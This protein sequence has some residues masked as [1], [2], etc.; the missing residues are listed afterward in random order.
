MST[1]STHVLDSATGRPAVGMEIELEAVR[2]GVWR[3]LGRGVTDD[4]GRLNTWL[5]TELT[6]QSNTQPNTGAEV[7]LGPGR[8]RLVFD[9]GGWSADLD[10]ECF[11]PEVGITFTVD[12]DGSHFHVPLL[13]AAYAYSTYRGS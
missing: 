10:R 8:Y 4:D 6:T 5:N 7:T 1:L 12:D 9:T 11:Y 13:L 2:E 3:T